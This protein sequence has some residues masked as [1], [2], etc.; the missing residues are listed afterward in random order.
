MKKK[1]IVSGLVP[2]PI[3][4]T[5][6]SPLSKTVYILGS[7]GF[8]REIKSYI[9]SAYNTLH[10]HPEIYFVDDTNKDSLSTDDYKSKIL[11]DYHNSISIMGSGRPD[12][13]KKMITQ[14]NGELFNMICPEAH[15]LTDNIGQGVVAAPGSV[16]STNAQIGYHVLINYCATIGHDTIINGLSTISP[17]ANIGGY[18]LIGRGTLIGSGAQIRE[19]LKIGNGVIV[20][21]GAVVTKDVPHDHIAVGNPA[22]MFTKEEWRK[23]N[24]HHDG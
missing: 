11:G 15:I 2:V 10:L 8:A 14:I 19:H 1:S 22:R 17:G 12:V 9:L 18:C 24:G 23:S 6:K 20:G 13:K 5:K 4:P 7:S 21:M 16:I 3:K